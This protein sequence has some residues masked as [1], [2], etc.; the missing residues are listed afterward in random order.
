MPS[1]SDMIREQEDKW[2]RN[3]R[4]FNKDKDRIIENFND[5]IK[6]LQKATEEIKEDDRSDLTYL[7]VNTYAAIDRIIRR[8]PKN[9][10]W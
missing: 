7:I 4:F 3:R 8:R 10:L 1:K 5:T 6:R 2:R 9:S